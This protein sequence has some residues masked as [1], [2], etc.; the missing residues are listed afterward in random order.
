MRKKDLIKINVIVFYLLINLRDGD[1]NII[2]IGNN[3]NVFDCLGSYVY[4]KL[5]NKSKF[6]NVFFFENFDILSI[7]KQTIIVDSAMSRTGDLSKNEIDFC[8]FNNGNIASFIL[9]GKFYNNL[10]SFSSFLIEDRDLV[11]T[12]GEIIFSS[13]SKFINLKNY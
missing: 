4:N 12:S 9:L 6:S 10:K 13:L 5:K 2:C 3:K 8:R 1:T 11:I 7:K